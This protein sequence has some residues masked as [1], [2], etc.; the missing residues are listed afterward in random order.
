[1]MREYFEDFKYMLQQMNDIG[2]PFIMHVE[3][4]TWGFMMWAFGIE[5]NGD[6]TSVDVSVGSSGFEDVAA[7]EDDAGGFGKALLH[8]RDLYAPEA[9]MGWHASNFRFNSQPE[10]VTQFYSSMG[11]WD[12]LVGEG[13]HIPGSN[14]WWAPLEAD[15]ISAHMAWHQDV[16]TS[17]RLPLLSWQRQIG[18]TDYH[19]LNESGDYSLIESYAANGVVGFAFGLETNTENADDAKGTENG[20]TETP[21][22]GHEAGGTALEMRPR[23]TAYYQ[24]PVSLPD[25]SICDGGTNNLRNSGT[26]YPGGTTSGGTTTGTTT[27]GGTSTGTTSG[28]TTSG[29][30]T[31]GSSTGGDSESGSDGSDGGDES[32]CSCDLAN[33]RSPKPLNYWW[34]SLV[35]FVALR[36][37]GTR[38]AKVAAEWANRI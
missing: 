13:G 11:E 27:G 34:L 3:P 24:S 21:P 2:G 7:F 26:Q 37:R 20:Y 5:G 17:A 25:G 30:T 31:T 19:F 16:T 15:A 8:L 22:S 23:L 28:G 1:V 14:D 9:R 38:R 18:Y 35:G 4:D 10:V 33:D 32:G 12:L 29:G 36:R 6:A